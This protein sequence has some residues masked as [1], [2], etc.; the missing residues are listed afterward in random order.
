MT[1][2]APQAPPPSTPDSID[3][4][5][6]TALREGAAQAGEILRQVVPNT[7]A[8]CV[9]IK[10]GLTHLVSVVDGER[11]VWT[12]GLPDDGQFGPTRVAQVEK[13]LLLALL[14]DPD[15]GELRASG[16]TALPNGQGVEAYTVLIPPA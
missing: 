3:P 14:I 6:C 5:A 16:W 2:H 11:I 9:A 15:P 1:N 12:N 4:V 8:L 7:R 13:A 10:D